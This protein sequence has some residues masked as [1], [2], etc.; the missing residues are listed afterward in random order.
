[1]Q[2][3]NQNK[4]GK[5]R[6][7]NIWDKIFETKNPKKYAQKKHLKQKYTWKQKIRNMTQK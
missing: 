7:S 3:K 6:K 1:M 5:V 2:N 4:K